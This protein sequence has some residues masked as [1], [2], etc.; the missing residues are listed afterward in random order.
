MEGGGDSAPSVCVPVAERINGRISGPLDHSGPKLASKC[1][2]WV[3][4]YGCGYGLLYVY[5]L[6][7]ALM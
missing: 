2:I 4:G 7:H 5:V 6:K 3:C 1:M